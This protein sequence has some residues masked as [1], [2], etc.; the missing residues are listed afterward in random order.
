[1]RDI[2]GPDGII[3]SILYTR[4]IKEAKQDVKLKDLNWEIRQVEVKGKVS[5]KPELVPKLVHQQVP[6]LPEAMATHMM[7]Q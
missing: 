5:P 1:M 6:Q 4:T 7:V 2:A 3:P